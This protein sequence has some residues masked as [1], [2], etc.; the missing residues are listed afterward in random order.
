MYYSI[1]TI[2]GS[3]ENQFLTIDTKDISYYRREKIKK[4]NDSIND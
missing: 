1:E 4:I 2:G 3:A